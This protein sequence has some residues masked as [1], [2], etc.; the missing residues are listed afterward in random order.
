MPFVVEEHGAVL[1]QHF[2]TI[3]N[4]AVGCLRDCE[5]DLIESVVCI[6]RRIG[7]NAENPL[8][9]SNV[10]DKAGFCQWGCCSNTLEMPVGRRNE[11]RKIVASLLKLLA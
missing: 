5:H 6:K 4:N 3:E 1:I 2:A 10:I 9:V 8:S 11:T 7:D